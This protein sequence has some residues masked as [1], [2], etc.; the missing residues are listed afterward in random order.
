MFTFFFFLSGTSANLENFQAYLLEGLERWNEDCAA[1]ASINKPKSSLRCYSASLQHSL[2]ELSQHLLGSSLVQD[3]SKPREYT[4]MCLYCHACICCCCFLLV[5]FVQTFVLKP[6]FLFNFVLSGELIGVE[7]LCSQQSWEFRDNFGR[8]PDAPDRIPDNLVEAEDE[9]FGD[10]DEEQDLTISSLSLMSTK[11][12]IHL[13]RDVPSSSRSSQDLLS[14]P[15]EE[16]SLQAA[17][18]MDAITWWTFPSILTDLLAAC[19]CAEDRTGLQGSIEWW[20]WPGTSSSSEKS[21]VSQK[22][23]Q[24]TSSGCGIGCRTVT[25]RGFPIWRGT[26][27][28]FCKAGSRPPTR[29]PQPAM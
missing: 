11:D 23:K 12:A 25:N 24:L 9:G 5:F 7:Y 16:V 6:C 29:K 28:G 19:R 13:S 21:L 15:Q 3:Y 20:S 17:F 8:D 27:R 1:A 2:N 26:G 4:G 22:G 18:T 10:E 14:E